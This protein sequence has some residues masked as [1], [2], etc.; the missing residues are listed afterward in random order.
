MAEKIEVEFAS[1][2]ADGI[3]KIDEAMK[4][5]NSSRLTNDAIVTLLARS[6]KLKRSDVEIVLWGIETL[7][8][9]YLK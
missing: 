3:E 9:R 8:E 5:I 1:D 6:T 7:K 2:I 4:V